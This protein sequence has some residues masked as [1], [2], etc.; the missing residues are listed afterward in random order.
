MLFQLVQLNIKK[1]KFNNNNNNF[2]YHIGTQLKYMEIVQLCRYIQK[3]LDYLE[4][5]LICFKPIRKYANERIK[6]IFGNI[7][8]PIT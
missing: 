1:K 7:K 3:N 6:Y 2:N 4:A 8:T 5:K